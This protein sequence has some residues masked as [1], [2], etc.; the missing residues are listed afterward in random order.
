MQQT[1]LQQGLESLEQFTDSVQ[2]FV[3]WLDMA[4]R[5][6]GM[7]TVPSVFVEP[8]ERQQEQLNVRNSLLS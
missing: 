8:L 7:F 5:R 2:D 3:A 6:M 4:E 1:Q